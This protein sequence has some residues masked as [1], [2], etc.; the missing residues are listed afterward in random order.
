M[1]AT[2]INLKDQDKDKAIENGI[3]F[4]SMD[5]EKKKL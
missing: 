1:T 2:P 4:Y 5:D 3:N